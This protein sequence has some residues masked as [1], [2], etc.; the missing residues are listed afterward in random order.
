MHFHNTLYDILQDHGHLGGDRDYI[1]YVAIQQRLDRSHF[2]CTYVF[3]LFLKSESNT[4]RFFL[5]NITEVL[6]F[7]GLVLGTTVAGNTSCWWST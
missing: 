3:F 2:G 5:L 1:H 4:L 7:H 6:S